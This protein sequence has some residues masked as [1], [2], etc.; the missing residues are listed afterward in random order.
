MRTGR[1]GW[2]LGD[3]PHQPKVTRS[4]DGCCFSDHLPGTSG[5]K[6]KNK[7]Q[8]YSEPGSG[9]MDANAGTSTIAP[10]AGHGGPSSARQGIGGHFLTGPVERRSQ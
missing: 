1:T 8:K 3:G 5:K 6:K 10:P 7:K 4:L 2:A 9:L